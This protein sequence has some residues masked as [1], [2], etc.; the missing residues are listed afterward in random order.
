MKTEKARVTYPH[1]TLIF[2]LLLVMELAIA[3]MSAL[4]IAA[5]VFFVRLP[6]APGDTSLI[7]WRMVIVVLFGFI[8]FF[9]ALLLALIPRKVVQGWS[10]LRRLVK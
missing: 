3:A 10:S 6:I 5:F 1:L 4:S 7:F 2:A 8:A 9:S